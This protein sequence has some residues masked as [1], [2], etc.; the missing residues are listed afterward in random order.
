MIN[1]QKKKFAL[2]AVMIV[3]IIIWDPKNKYS[4]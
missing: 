2:S 4:E 3:G 1:L